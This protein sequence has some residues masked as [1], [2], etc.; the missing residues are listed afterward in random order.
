MAE[1][2]PDEYVAKAIQDARRFQG[3]WDAG[4]SG[5]LAAH[6]FRLAREREGLLNTIKELEAHNAAL[7]AAV[8]SR[9]GAA[10][11]AP[12][13][14]VDLSGLPPAFLD[15]NPAATF[16]P[17][18]P[19]PEAEF[20]PTLVGSSL[21]PA[22]LE[23]AWSA[24]KSRRDEMLARA[25]GELPMEPIAV[26]EIRPPGRRPK[27]VGV[28]GR[29]GSGKNVVAGMVPDA[30][31]IQL[32][33]PLYAMV[34][35]ML[36]VSEERLRD[37]DFKERTLDWLGKSPRQLLQ[38]LGTEWGRSTIRDDVWLLMAKSR[39]EALLEDGAACVVV[40]DLRFDNEAAMIRGLGG[41]VWEVLRPDAADVAEHSSERGLSPHLVDR[42]I[43]NDGTLSQ[44]RLHVEAALA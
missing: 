22:A 12:P 4:T 39:I 30:K 2:L 14:T 18:V 44:L 10:A 17:A 33:D 32:A 42:T 8:E 21:P 26:R 3:C 5:T 41:E 9:L 6:T 34:S 24:M 40:A 20:T 27:V 11:A 28:S 43:Q 15:A 7:R 37:R 13:V 16:V 29:A 23:T 25:R 31:V 1:R 35:V 19:V 38:T 36:G